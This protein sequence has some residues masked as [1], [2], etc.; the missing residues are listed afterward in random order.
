MAK[1]GADAILES[2]FSQHPLCLEPGIK[3]VGGLGS[4]PGEPGKN[5]LEKRF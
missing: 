5:P 3:M 4:V 2:A 1:D